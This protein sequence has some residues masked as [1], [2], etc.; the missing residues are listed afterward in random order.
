MD[1]MEKY[2]NVYFFKK[3]SYY[4][5][6]TYHRAEENI[7][8]KLIMVYAASQTHKKEYL[9]KKSSTLVINTNQRPFP[10]LRLSDWKRDLYW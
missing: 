10:F 2:F 6:F 9:P 4:I 3:K 8:G 1:K 5:S 7:G